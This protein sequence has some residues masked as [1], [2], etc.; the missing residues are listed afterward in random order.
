MYK[1]V[2][3]H[4]PAFPGHYLDNHGVTSAGEWLGS[5]ANPPTTRR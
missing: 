5:L 1:N 3:N 4:Q 2:P